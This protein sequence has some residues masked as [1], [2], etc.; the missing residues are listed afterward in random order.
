MSDDYKYEIQLDIDG[1]VF[2]T[3]NRR[4]PLGTAILVNDPGVPTD[5]SFWE[6]M[7]DTIH[8]NKVD[9]MPLC[10]GA[11]I[12][13]DENGKGTLTIDENLPNGVWIVEN[14]G[15]TYRLDGVT[16][17]TMVRPEAEESEDIEVSPVAITFE[18]NE[19]WFEGENE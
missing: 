19:L 5:A 6:W 15:K 9:M 10:A 3:G 1:K 14:P 12:R 18:V 8:K 16:G 2:S 13:V 4:I 7:I 11:R 17:P